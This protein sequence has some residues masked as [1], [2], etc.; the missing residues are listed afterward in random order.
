MMLRVEALNAALA[1]IPEELIRY[2]VCWGSWP[3]MRGHADANWEK[4]R[5][6][7]K[8]AQLASQHLWASERRVVSVT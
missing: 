5:N 8:G 6:I 4:Y 2:H 7:V 3:G 1:G